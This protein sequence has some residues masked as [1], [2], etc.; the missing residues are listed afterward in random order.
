MR[1]RVAFQIERVVE[2]FAA[3]GTEIALDVRVTLHVSV[4]QSLEGET[5]GA[6]AAREFGIGI[7]VRFVFGDLFGLLRRVRFG[8]V[9][10]GRVFGLS[11][12]SFAASYHWIL[13]TVASVDE[14]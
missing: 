4:E 5:L 1:A 9:D 3:E 13:D 14:F 7:F 10:G 12:A 11:V 2:S 6:E 8:S